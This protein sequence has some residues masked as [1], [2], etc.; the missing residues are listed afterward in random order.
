MTAGLRLPDLGDIYLPYLQ[1][2]YT[3]NGFIRQHVAPLG[4]FQHKFHLP[5]NPPVEFLPSIH[6][7]SFTNN[8]SGYFLPFSTPS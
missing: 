1:F 8:F 7:F 2:N 6:G 3:F 5:E 4:I